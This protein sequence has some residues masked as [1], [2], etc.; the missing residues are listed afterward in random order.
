MGPEIPQRRK[1]SKIS[2]VP[3]QKKN[4][5]PWLCPRYAWNTFQV[6]GRALVLGLEIPG[7][8]AIHGVLNKDD[9][10]D[11]N[12]MEVLVFLLKSLSVDEGKYHENKRRDQMK[13]RCPLISDYCVF[14]FKKMY[15]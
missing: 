10:D 14:L 2:V 5:I 11:D 6:V 15:I 1:Y 9:D 4:Q 3:K 13:P 7:K 12:N 8:K